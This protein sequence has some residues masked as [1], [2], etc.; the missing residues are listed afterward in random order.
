MFNLLNTI[1]A[2]M[3]HEE[4]RRQG[5]TPKPQIARRKQGKKSD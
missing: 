5:K 4:L 3:R 2:E 1:F